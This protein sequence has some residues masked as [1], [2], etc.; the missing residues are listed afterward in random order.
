MGNSKRRPLSSLLDHVLTTGLLPEPLEDQGRP[1]VPDRDG[2]EPALGML[3]E[4]QD[5]SCQAS[6]RGEQSVELAALLGLIEPPQSGEDPL[7]GASALPAVLDDLEVGAGSGGLGAEKHGA[8]QTEH[9]GN[10]R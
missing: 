5:G 2:P 7:P 3:G 10:G 4:Q 1:D 6:S 8:L 9:R